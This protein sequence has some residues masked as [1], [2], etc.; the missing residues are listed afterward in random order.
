MS[1]VQ[2]VVSL[3]SNVSLKSEFV[4]FHLQH[5]AC[6][7]ESHLWDFLDTLYLYLFLLLFITIW[8]LSD[9]FIVL[10]FRLFLS[11]FLISQFALLSLQSMVYNKRMGLR[12]FVYSFSLPHQGRKKDLYL[13]YLYLY[14]IHYRFL[15]YFSCYLT[16]LIIC[17]H[18][19]YWFYCYYSRPIVQLSFFVSYF[20]NLVV[21]QGLFFV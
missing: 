19:S 7:N 5:C 10:D 15:F 20:L 8:K 9:Y 1:F 12:E 17:L 2:F 18:R 6:A 11:L 13:N 3:V 21:F 16:F 4:W 14:Q